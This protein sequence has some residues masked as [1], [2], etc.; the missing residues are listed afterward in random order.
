MPELAVQRI[1]QIPWD[2]LL[3]LAFVGLGI[4]LLFDRL[5]W[6]GVTWDELAR[7]QIAWDIAPTGGVFETQLDPSQ[8]RLS[9]LWGAL[10]L[11][12]LGPAL[13]NFKLAYA[14]VGLAGGALLFLLLRQRCSTGTAMLVAGFYCC[15]PY[16]LAASRS[17]ATAGDIMVAFLWLA[18][19]GS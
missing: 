5:D 9:H 4:F 12:T 19:I 13:F 7:Y 10:F 17:G 3:G 16:V 18:F 11:H 2:T 1:R 6:N 15:C 14:L 8:G